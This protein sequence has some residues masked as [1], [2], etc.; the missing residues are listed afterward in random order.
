MHRLIAVL[1]ALLFA[2]PAPA[3]AQDVPP[4]T[5]V[6]GPK[7][8]IRTSMGDI[9]LQ[10]DPGHAPLTVANFLRYAK[11]GH[12]DG[13]AV[14]RVVAGFVVQMG[15]WDADMHARPTHDPIPL[16]ADNGLTNLRGTVAMARGE[17]NSATAEF[18]INLADNAALDHQP[19]DT[20][21]ATGYTVFGQ[22][23]VGMDVVDKIAAVPVGD[24]GPMP[25]AAPVTPI[26]V[27]KVSVLPDTAP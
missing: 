22:V 3:Y 21:N 27:T 8:L 9:T 5:P 15:S 6:A 23:V 17:P 1:A 2:L 16:E 18:F 14:Y 4:A 25:G 12:F 7:V 26:V 24:R 10:L 13:T 20:A 11:E 19:A